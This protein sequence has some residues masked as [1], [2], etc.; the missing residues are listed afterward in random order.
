MILFVYVIVFEI[1]KI[2][3]RFGIK[4]WLSSFV[5][6]NVCDTLMTLGQGKLHCLHSDFI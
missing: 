5:I 1:V 3:E 4:V 2:V 6:N